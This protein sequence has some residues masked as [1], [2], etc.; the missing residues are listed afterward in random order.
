MGK[1]SRAVILALAILTGWT[2]AASAAGV[3]IVSKA[4]ESAYGDAKA[5]FIQ[6]AY[7]LQLPAFDPKTIELNGTASDDAALAALK[8]K[9]PTLVYAVGAY[10]AKKVRQTIPDI[11]I[12]YSMVYYPEVEGFTDEPKMVGIASL[13]PAK[14]L[15]SL[16]RAL[17]GK[18]KATVFVHA[19]AISRS[20]PNLLSK[21]NSEG[22]EAQAKSVA[23]QADLQT[24]FDSM[25][26]QAKV[27]VLLPDPILSNPDAVR[28]VVSRC[29]EM[30]IMPVSFS[31]SLVAEGVLCASFYAPD[32]VGNKA[33]RVAQGILAS[34]KMPEDKVVV[35][36]DSATAL[37]KGT[38]A[39]LGLSIPKN[40]RVEITYE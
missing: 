4:G 7:S 11:W 16:V 10:A 24:I 15:L 31:E 12:V 26:D 23:T 19:D 21:L 3:F 30:K 5:G 25:K 28:F 6:M 33:A 17:G 14:G 8:A 9:A 38:A 35:P 1:R 39:A 34:G 37:N 27:V 32:T 22:F 29:V 20:V 36:G 13:G 18:P 2:L 40:L